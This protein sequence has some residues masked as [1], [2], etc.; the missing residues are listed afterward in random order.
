MFLYLHVILR[1]SIFLHMYMKQYSRK[2]T[3]LKKE[4]KELYPSLYASLSF[5]Y[6]RQD[7]F[8]YFQDS[9]SK[10]Y[11][12]IMMELVY[13]TA[14]QQ[15]NFTGMQWFEIKDLFSNKVFRVYYSL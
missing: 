12:F 3:L 1:V 5:L 11:R 8:F 15:E 10:K 9:S 2:L 14:E 7:T 6:H 13:L 4:L